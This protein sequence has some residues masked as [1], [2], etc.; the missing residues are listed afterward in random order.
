MCGTLTSTHLSSWSNL[1][2]PLQED[3][4]PEREEDEAKG[5]E[6]EGDFEGDLFDLPSD[7]EKDNE[8][9]ELNE[10]EEQRLDQEMG[11]VGEQGQVPLSPS[12]CHCHASPLS[13]HQACFLLQ[14]SLWIVV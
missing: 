11:D 9:G 3:K 4:I 2:G 6:M 10:D 1:P 5:V 8:E 14:V 12:S 13:N 7:A